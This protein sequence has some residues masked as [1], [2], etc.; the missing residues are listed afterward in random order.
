M[1]VLEPTS[2]S[3]GNMSTHSS[4]KYIQIPY[5]SSE[6]GKPSPL[7]LLATTV[8]KI[9][10]PSPRIESARNRSPVPQRTSAPTTPRQRSGAPS[11]SP[12]SVAPHLAKVPNT[13]SPLH[14]VTPLPV[15]YPMYHVPLPIRHSPYS[16]GVG[17]PAGQQIVPSMRFDVPACCGLQY[18]LYHDMYHMNQAMI[19]QLPVM[20]P[21]LGVYPHHDLPLARLPSSLKASSVRRRSHHRIVKRLRRPMGEIIDVVSL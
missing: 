11:T 1:T 20:S 19:P 12:I 15:D 4:S 21:F 13:P 2:S 16:V 18:P 10:T 6:L 8:N 14:R 3:L 9:G 17:L 5:D 7:A